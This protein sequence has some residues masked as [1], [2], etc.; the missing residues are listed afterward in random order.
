MTQLCVCGCNR[1][2]V[3]RPGKP[4]TRG[5][6]YS[7]YRRWLA[8]GKPEELRPPRDWRRGRLESYAELRGWGQTIQQAADRLGVTYRTATRYEAELRGQRAVRERKAC[9][10][11]RTKIHGHGYCHACYQ[12]WVAAGRPVSGPPRPMSTDE[13]SFA[14]QAAARKR[15]AGQRA[16]KESAAEAA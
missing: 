2:A 5:F 13:R 1:P 3:A 8:Q 16:R 7:C 10:C 15:W 12:R 4:A 6:R 14:L 11:G 9:P